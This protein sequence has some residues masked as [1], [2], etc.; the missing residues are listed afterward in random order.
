M[1][2]TTNLLSVTFL[3]AF[4]ATALGENLLLDA[5]FAPDPGPEF[6]VADADYVGG[7]QVFSNAFPQSTPSLEGVASY[8]GDDAAG[9]FYGSF[10]SGGD[11][12]MIQRVTEDQTGLTFDGETF[13]AT[14]RMM[15]SS[16]DSIANTQNVALTVMNFFDSSFTLIETPN[17]NVVEEIL[18]GRLPDMPVD[19]WVEATLE[20]TAPAGTYA[21]E[22]VHVFVQTANNFDGG[23]VAEG[24]AVWVDA[25]ELIMV[26]QGYDLDANGDSVVNANDIDYLFASGQAGEVATWLSEFGTLSGDANLDKSVDLLDLSAL[27]SNF[28]DAGGWADGN[29]NGDSGVDLLDLS[30]LATNF[31]TSS[32]PEPASAAML[33]LAGLALRRR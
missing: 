15:T 13:Q 10:F 19:T 3:T 4:A 12:V 32:V 33:A 1:N 27:A 8:D 18:D 29:F 17:N 11:S 14:V 5:S 2:R 20:G 31:G 26:D 25:N 22:L 21:V 6:G 28:N 23:F 7:W 16:L 30:I 9:K 24:G